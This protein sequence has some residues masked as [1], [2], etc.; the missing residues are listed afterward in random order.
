MTDI[1]IARSIKL[2]PI[3]K[4]SEKLKIDLSLIEPYGHYKAK[5]DYAQLENLKQKIQMMKIGVK[6]EMR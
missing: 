6:C 5:I 3:T 4:V 1:E 2:E